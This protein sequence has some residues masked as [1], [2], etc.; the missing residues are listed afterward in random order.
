LAGYKRRIYI[1]NP[2]F[3]IKFS[4]LVSFIIF[5]S[6]VIYP[7]TIHNL[8]S[9]IVDNI[10]AS[11]PEL[12]AQLT[13]RKS[14]L[15]VIL[16]LWQFGFTLLAFITCIFMTHKVAGP[17]Y[18]LQKYLSAIRDG[19][20]SGKLFFRKG[21]YFQEVAADINDTFGAIQENYHNDFVYLSEVNEY[22]NNL[23]LVVP[24]DKKIVLKEISDKLIEIQGRFQ[25]QE[26]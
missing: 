25:P 3:Q 23:A 15:L 11:S 9:T 16:V 26:K 22:L 24:D 4:L 10:S 1:I 21:D 8:I 6:S 19:Q 2:S 7:L 5:L 14:T 17:L 20:Y 18:K 12:S 13:D